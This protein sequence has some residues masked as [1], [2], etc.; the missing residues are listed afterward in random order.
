MPRLLVTDLL[1]LESQSLCKFPHT[2]RL[3]RA[4]H[5]LCRACA[6]S[7]QKST[8]R[9]RAKPMYAISGDGADIVR[10]LTRMIE[11]ELPHKCDGLGLWPI[12]PPFG[13]RMLRVA[14]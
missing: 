4:D 7:L 8:L 10:K 2:E 14:I 5:A 1:V 11:R 6:Q 13:Q 12:Q 9:V 3:K